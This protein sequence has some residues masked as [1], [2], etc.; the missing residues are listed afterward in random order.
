MGDNNVADSVREFSS[1]RP[2]AVTSHDASQHML[3]V[4]KSIGGT[5]VAANSMR[6]SKRSIW[7]DRQRGTFSSRQGRR[8]RFGRIRN[9]AGGEEEGGEEEHV[10]RQGHVGMEGNYAVRLTANTVMSSEGGA[11]PVWTPRTAARRTS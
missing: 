8:R 1:L 7:S 4:R 6:C 9:L 5:G 3:P 10:L 11:S 2:F